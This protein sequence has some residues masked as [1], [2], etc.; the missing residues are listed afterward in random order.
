MTVNIHLPV[1]NVNI[2]EILE[3]YMHPKAIFPSSNRPMQLDVFIPSRS[4]A[5]EYQGPQ[6]YGDVAVNSRHVVFST[7]RTY[8]QRDKEKRALCATNNIKLIEV[9][10]WWNRTQES[11]QEIIGPSI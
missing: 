4:L 11:L 10:Y 7:T 2:A 1:P 5:F 6:H 9:P 3:D 8:E